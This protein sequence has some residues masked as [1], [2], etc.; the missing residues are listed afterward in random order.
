MSPFQSLGNDRRVGQHLHQI[1]PDQ[2]IQLIG[3][4]IASR[5]GPRMK[6]VQRIDPPMTDV[7]M[8]F[9]MQGTPS[10]AQLAVPATHPTTEQVRILFVVAR[11]SLLVLGQFLLYP[12]KGLSVHNCGYRYGDPFCFWTENV[13]LSL[14]DGPQSG[15]ALV[16]GDG[17]HPIGV[18]CS[19]I[20][21]IG[22]DASNG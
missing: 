11:G 10:G 15:E 7:V 12:I 5:T 1:L 6:G 16:G 21:W 2:F 20:S 18:Y 14:P 3:R 4:G 13:R 8:I 17:A 9:P 22:Q 19:G